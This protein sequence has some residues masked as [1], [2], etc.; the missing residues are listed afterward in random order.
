MMGA[1]AALAATLPVAAA[2]AASFVGTPTGPPPSYYVPKHAKARCRQQ[3][4]KQTV[5]LRMQRHGKKV[6]VRQVRCLRVAPASGSGGG[7]STSSSS[8]TAGPTF[9]ANLP[10]G[11]I[12]VSIVTTAS[13][14]TYATN[15]NQALSVGA[16]GV[17]AGANGSDLTPVLVSAPAHGT[18][19]L[20]RNGTFSYTPATNFSGVERFTYAIRNSWGAT[21]APAT[22]T[23]NV[24]PVAYGASTA[25]PRG[26]R[27]LLPRARC[28]PATSAPG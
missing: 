19:V 2:R 24:L 25:S 26:R 8:S 12:T 15:A 13:N 11:A 27:S 21:S 18:L 14:H 22:V 10:A 1:L 23:L 3:Y 28:W 17:L 7:L 16:S 6:T 4:T 20:N 5:T 9:P